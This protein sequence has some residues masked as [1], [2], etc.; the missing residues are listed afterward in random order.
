MTA[1]ELDKKLTE[2]L[3]PVE[4]LKLTENGYGYA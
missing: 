1:K 3:G 2:K 4:S